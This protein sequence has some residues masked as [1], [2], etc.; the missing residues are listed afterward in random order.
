MLRQALGGRTVDGERGVILIHRF[1][2]PPALFCALAISAAFFFSAIASAQSSKASSWTART[3][4]GQPDI[5]GYWSGATITPFERPAALGDKAFLTEEEAAK[6]EEQARRSG[7]GPPRANN[8]V[9][10]EL[11]LDRGSKV[12]KTRQSSL[13]VEPENGLVPLTAAAEAKRDYNRA[14]ETDSY[15]YMGVW[16]RCITRGVP[17]NMFP[18]GHNNAYQIIQPPG[19]VVIISEMIHD[20]R[21]IPLDGSP[22]PPSSVRLWNGDS[23]G[24]WEGNTL[25][26][27]TTNFNAK[28]SIATSAVEGRIKGV[29]QSEALHL[30]ERFTRT[31]AGTLNYEVTIQDPPMYAKPWKV[32]IPLVRDENY[33]MFEYACSEGNHAVELILGGGRARD[34]AAR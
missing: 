26:V 10:A 17:A 2:V 14:H 30:V 23:R 7:G 32:A 11:W 29:P 22:H 4:T 8:D 3:A 34:R 21:V 28:G 13:V 31:D 24:H 20:A 27:E 16:D 6:L 33:R 5:E 1:L 18:A 25:V 12:V 15:E 9:G 19:K